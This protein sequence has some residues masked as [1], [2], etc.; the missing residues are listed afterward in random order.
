[1]NHP[2]PSQNQQQTGLK[3]AADASTAQYLVGNWAHPFD[4]HNDTDC[5]IAFDCENNGIAAMQI[6]HSVRGWRPA[7]WTEMRDLRDSILNGN[8]DAIDKPE[9]YG[10]SRANELPD[11]ATSSVTQAPESAVAGWGPTGEDSLNLRDTLL[12]CVATLESFVGKQDTREQRSAAAAAQRG[13]MAM[14]KHDLQIKAGDG[15]RNDASARSLVAG[16]LEYA[17]KHADGADEPAN[18]DCRKTISAAERYL[19][20]NPA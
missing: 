6:H 10:L 1:M 8:P 11:W 3:V 7:R 16:L 12:H 14:K 2:T 17:E 13:R 18:G 4:G 20:A 5:R 9:D 15:A 19:K